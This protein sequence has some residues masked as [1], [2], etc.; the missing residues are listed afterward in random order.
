[1]G[2]IPGG[3]PGGARGEELYSSLVSDA[4]RLLLLSCLWTPRPR[5]PRPPRPRPPPLPPCAPAL[6]KSASPGESV[7]DSE[8]VGKECVGLVDG[9]KSEAL[10]LRRG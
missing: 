3:K 7:D 5:P 1:M 2:G 10:A 8:D 4:A 9:V 6:S